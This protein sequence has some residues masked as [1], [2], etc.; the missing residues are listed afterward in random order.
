M[1][2]GNRY[3]V[4]FIDDYSRKLWI[5]LIKR[6]NEIFKVFKNFK[7]MVERKSSHNLKVLKMDS[8]GEYVSNDFGRFYDQEGITYEV[9]PP[10]TLQ[11]NSVA[12]RKNQLI[13]NM[14][15]IMLKGKN[16]PKELWGEAVSA[17]A[18]SLNRCP[19]NKLEKVT[20]EEAWSGFKPNLNHLIVF[21]FVAYQYVLGKLRKK[22]GD[23]VELMIVVG[24]HSTSGYKLYD[25]TNRRILINRDVIVDEIKELQQLVT[26]YVKDVSGYSIENSF[27]IEFESVE[28]ALVEARMEENVR[29]STRQR[30]LPQRLKYCEMFRDN[31]ANDDGEFVHFALMAESKS[32][33][34]KETLSDPK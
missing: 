17:A 22:L 9:A 23:K 32:V 20:L 3:F 15:K 18:Y 8:G 14:V 5:Y 7:S 29:R 19:T 13:M 10:Y 21:G 4:T 28:P 16:L 27:S 12:E 26:S 30:G 33:K 34:R 25:T 1:I 31:K 2:G 24:Y 6:K 11:Q